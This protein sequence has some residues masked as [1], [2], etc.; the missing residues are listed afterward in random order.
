MSTIKRPKYFYFFDSMWI[1]KWINEEMVDGA[2]TDLDTKEIRM[3][4]KK[5]DEDKLRENLLHELEHVIYTDIFEH[6][7]PI[8]DLDDADKVEEIL[9]R[10]V[11][12][13]RK[14]LYNSNI[15]LIK[16]LFQPKDK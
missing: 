14:Q 12:P 8:L 3:F 10:L 13:R 6:I 1:I 15:D 16:Y 5:T 2:D 11:T 7:L 4:Y 9:V